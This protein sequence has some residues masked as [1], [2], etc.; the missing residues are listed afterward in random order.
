MTARAI[1]RRR[2][3]VPA[4]WGAGLA[5][6]AAWLLHRGAPARFAEFLLFPFCV[7]V[8]H[9][10]TRW[11]ERRPWMPP[12]AIR[13]LAGSTRRPI[14]PRP[15]PTWTAGSCRTVRP[16]RPDER[17]VAVGSNAGRHRA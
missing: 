3:F 15:N 17:R 8:V 14:Y 5:L 12:L 4:L 11:L 13:I 1:A 2:T 6:L 10:V 16:T 9:E 7:A